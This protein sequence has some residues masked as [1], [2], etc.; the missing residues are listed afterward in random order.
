MLS[1][2]EFF[3]IKDGRDNFYL[4]EEKDA[5]KVFGYTKLK[6]RIDELIDISQGTKI[7]PRQLWWGSYGCG[8]THHLNY[9]KRRIENEDLP[10]KPVLFSCPDVTTKSPFNEVLYKMVTG[11]QAESFLKLLRA[12]DEKNRDWL[13]GL[14]I[15]QDVKQAFHQMIHSPKESDLAWAYLA[16]EAIGGSGEMRAL[17]VGKKQLN[18][19]SEFAGV[20]SVLGEVFQRESGKTLLYLLDEFE[21]LQDITNSDADKKWRNAIRRLLDIK[22]VGFIFAIAAEKAPMLPTIMQAPEIIRRIGYDFVQ[23]IQ[24]LQDTELESFLVGLFD[25]VIDREKLKVLED[26]ENLLSIPNYDNSLFPFT[27]PAFEGYCKYLCQDR[28]N[29]KPSE[30]LKNLEKVTTKAYRIGKRIIDRKLLEEDGK[31]V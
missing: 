22:H 19:G 26:T 10:F 4:D 3:C 30:A 20:I 27:K 24:P 18:D 29:A 21:G 14:E 13:N 9:L 11:A 5:L 1:Y 7:S 23:E 12:F 25:L 15:P 31:F 8:K 17:G 6:A 16:G 28:K 2:A